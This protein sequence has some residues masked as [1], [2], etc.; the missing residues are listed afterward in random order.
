VAERLTADELIEECVRDVFSC[1]DA[2]C[3]CNI[4]KTLDEAVRRMRERKGKYALRA[5]SP[6]E[7]TAA[8][9]YKTAYDEINKVRDRADKLLDAKY[10]GWNWVHALVDK[11]EKLCAPPPERATCTAEELLCLIDEA[12]VMLAEE[13]IRCGFTHPKVFAKLSAILFALRPRETR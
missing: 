7:P 12:G 2:N 13:E 6:S 9:D 10:L 5:E 11:L 8:P 4:C 3:P 1:A